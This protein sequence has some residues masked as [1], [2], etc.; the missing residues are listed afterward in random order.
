MLTATLIIKMVTSRSFGLLRRF[1]TSFDL[2]D[3]AVSMER[4]F[5]PDSEKSAVSEAE[6]KAEVIKKMQ[7]PMI[8]R[9]KTIIFPERLSS[10]VRLEQDLSPSL[11]FAQSTMD[12]FDSRFGVEDHLL[13]TVLLA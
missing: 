6:K 7:R 5:M 11:A 13:W 1:A 8:R 4:T 9:E 12:H 10:F 2:R 3:L